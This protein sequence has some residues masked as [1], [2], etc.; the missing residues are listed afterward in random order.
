MGSKSLVDD[1]RRALGISAILRQ[2]NILSFFRTIRSRLF[3]AFGLAA[4]MTVVSSL[5]ALYTSANL[6]ATLAEVLSRSMPATVESLRLAEEAHGLVASAPQLMTA[7]DDDHRSEIGREIARQSQLLTERIERLRDL[8]ASQNEELKIAKAAMDRQLGALDQAVASRIKIA[9]QRRALVRLVRKHHD[10]LLDAITPAIDDANFD[11]M[12][13]MQPQRAVEKIEFLRHLLEIQANANF[14]AGQ[15]IESSLVTDVASLSPIR[16]NIAMAQRDIENGLNGLPASPEKM[17]L[18]DLYGRLAS[19]AGEDGV[20]TQRLNELNQIHVAQQVFAEALSEASMLRQVVDRLTEREGVFARTLSIRADAQI[21]ASRTLL[22]ALSM[23]ALLAAALMAWLYVGRNIVG[24]LTLLATAMRR[25]A[26]GEMNTTIPVGGADEIGN[27]AKALLIFRQAIAEVNNARQREAS[28]AEESEARRRQLEV[29]AQNFER[30]VNDMVQ[31][32]DGASRSMDDCAHI[33]TEAAESNRAQAAAVTESSDEASVNVG[34][35]AMAAEQMAQSVEQ[36]SLQAVASAK[37]AQQATGEAQAII[38][39]VEQL[40]SSVEQINAV[41]NLIRG[42]AGQTNLLALN[43]TIEAARAGEAGRGFAVVAQEVK[44]LAA[45]TETATHEITRQ[46]STI[47]LTTS[48]VVQ[49]MNAIAG[50]IRQLD[51]NATGISEAVQQQDSVTKEIARSA[52]TAAEKTREVSSGITRV[53]EAA[54]KS[55]QV[56]TAVL[57]AGSELADR[58]NKLRGEVEYFLAQVRVV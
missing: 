32:L 28:R 18:S 57:N 52:G 51:V 2:L 47:E 15:L 12:T 14:L 31:S 36:I 23:G 13:Q 6:S 25:I 20:V 48:N 35:V 41:S 53:A 42:V 16:E 33:M 55:D 19:V 39:A 24:R 56:A 4:G 11:V 37:I 44:A 27:M 1:R 29:A 40:S 50:T 9:S 8:D 3:L 17:R 38:E 49:A 30:A 26:D 21:Q 22:I 43:A 7:E 46:I 45:Q 10:D 58:S 5:V 34:S 54:L